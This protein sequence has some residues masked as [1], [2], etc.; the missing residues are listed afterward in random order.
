MD[1][2]L[3][4]GGGRVV[5]TGQGPECSGGVAVAS[6]NMDREVLVSQGFFERPV[7]FFD[8]FG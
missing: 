7:Y 5:K 8:F 4:D 3:A 6:Q 1:E 2:Q